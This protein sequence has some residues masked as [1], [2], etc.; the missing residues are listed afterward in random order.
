MLHGEPR[1]RQHD[2]GNRAGSD[3]R[4]ADSPA[5]AE[6]AATGKRPVA[7]EPEPSDRGRR[8]SGE[9]PQPVHRTVDQPVGGGDEP[10]EQRGVL[11]RP[12]ASRPQAREGPS[13]QEEHEQRR[14]RHARLGQHADLEAVWVERL[15]VAPPVTDV[16]DREVVDPEP[17]QRLLGETAERDTPEVVAVAAEPARQMR[18]RPGRLLTAGEVVPG[19]AHPI[20]RI[21]DCGSR[22]A[23]GAD[24]RDG[25]GR[26]DHASD[27]AL[28][29]RRQPGSCVEGGEHP[30]D[31]AGRGRRSEQ[32]EQRRAN[33]AGGALIG[34]HGVDVE[35]HGEG[36]RDGAAGQRERRDRSRSTRDEGELDDADHRECDH[37]PSALTKR[38]R[39]QERSR[40]GGERR[41]QRRR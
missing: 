24:C 32:R 16:L 6:P 38:G 14:S 39:A 12:A 28:G 26:D 31:E 7:G 23:E 19:A 1:C 11:D 25:R 18:T 8:Q 33:G 20:D 37:R 27:P 2:C 5:D 35:Q 9:L 34:Q 29:R 3:R 10:S 21:V 15:L 36:D 40:C 13:R 17:R 30:P 22:P 41:P 4:G